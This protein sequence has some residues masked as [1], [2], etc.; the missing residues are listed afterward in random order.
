M[1]QKN[2]V[3]RK[4]SLP[5]RPFTHKAPKAAGWNLFGGLPNRFTTLYPKSSYALTHFTGRQLSPLFPEAF[6][7]TGSFG[8][9][10]VIIFIANHTLTTK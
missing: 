9:S 1:D 4:A 7:L 8:H 6:L 2:Q 3:S 10:L 5:H